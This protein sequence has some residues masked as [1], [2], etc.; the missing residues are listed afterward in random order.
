[1]STHFGVTNANGDLELDTWASGSSTFKSM[2]QWS[3]A[4]GNT[5]VGYN[6]LWSGVGS[7]GDGAGHD[8]VD[9]HITG[10]IFGSSATLSASSGPM[11]T[12]QDGGTFG[13][14]A[15]PS[16]NFSDSVGVGA[17]VGFYI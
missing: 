1:S 16:M 4:T 9:I 8:P 11:L 7:I 3:F 12:L 10:N 15:D 13:T 5:S 17:T 6:L 14:N 2:M